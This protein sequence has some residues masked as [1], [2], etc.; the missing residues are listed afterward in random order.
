MLKSELVVNI[1]KAM[2]EEGS[3]KLAQDALDIVLVEI[4][5]GLKADG[6]VQIP[7]F[8]TFKTK[9]RP[10]RMGPKPGTKDKMLYPAST[11]V[12]FKAGKELKAQVH[13]AP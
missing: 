5:N 4:A 2:G 9:V 10:E 12:A 8:G 13:K 11:S 1:Q 3:K 6:L 7:G